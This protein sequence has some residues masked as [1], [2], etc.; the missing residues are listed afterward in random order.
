[1]PSPTLCWLDGQ[2]MST[3]FYLPALAFSHRLSP[4]DFSSTYATRRMHPAAGCI[5]LASSWSGVR[6]GFGRPSEVHF[7]H[8]C[9]AS[10]GHLDEVKPTG[11]SAQ[12]DL[13]LGGVQQ[14]AAVRTVDA[15]G[16]C[17]RG[18]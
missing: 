13:R 11:Q 4:F 14:S 18:D 12:V 5:L 6:G 17:P 7:D 8:L 16:F 10:A 2:G 3:D 1:M 9:A 15:D